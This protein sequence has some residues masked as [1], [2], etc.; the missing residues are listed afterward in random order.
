ML[1]RTIVVLNPA[2]ITDTSI[3]PT[4]CP[5][6]EKCFPTGW[7]VFAPTDHMCSRNLSPRRL[8][9]SPGRASELVLESELTAWGLEGLR[10]VGMG[11][12]YAAG[13]ATRESP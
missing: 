1:H 4:L 3:S 9:V 10:R 8:P 5:G 13:T 6:D 7:S 2:Q 12:G 11:A